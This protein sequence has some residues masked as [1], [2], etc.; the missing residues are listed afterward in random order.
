MILG[1]VLWVMAQSNQSINFQKVTRGVGQFLMEER[2]LSLESVV[3]Q[4]CLQNNKKYYILMFNSPFL[5]STFNVGV[6]LF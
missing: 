2:H 6:I 3:N 1:M 5:P 4:S